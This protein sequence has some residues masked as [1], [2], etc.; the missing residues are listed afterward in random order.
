LSSS[1]NSTFFLSS[2]SSSLLPKQ[3]AHSEVASAGGIE[4]AS[5]TMGERYRE[6]QARGGAGEGL[7][8]EGGAG[9]RRRSPSPA[10]R[11]ATTT[12]T[13]AS[14]MGS[15]AQGMGGQQQQQQGKFS[16]AREEERLLGSTRTEA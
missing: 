5:S 3:A 6:G 10:S 9:L 14:P 12:T 2:P 13:G 11:G 8:M 1:K 15:G 4:G 16:S 7:M